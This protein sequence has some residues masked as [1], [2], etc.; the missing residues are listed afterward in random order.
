M[1]HV[2]E[3]KTA[4]GRAYSTLH[5][6]L[7]AG[8]LP[9]GSKVTASIIQVELGCSATPIR[10]ALSRLAGQNML[11]DRPSI[12]YFV[13][14]IDPVELKDLYAFAAILAQAALDT[15]DPAAVHFVQEDKT[16]GFVQRTAGQMVRAAAWLSLNSQ[17]RDIA[18]NI[19]DRLARL[20]A[21]DLR[22]FGKSDATEG[23]L[24][25]WIATGTRRSRRASLGRYFTRR[26]R[27]VLQIASIGLRGLE[28]PNNIESI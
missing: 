9:P 25:Q 8:S 6:K 4:F 10:E 12:G 16:D 27:A 21:I 5:G 20:D 3:C 24:E 1:H 19:D 7:R 23:D 17:M 28:G 18:I 15:V 13:P 22:L 14:T 26:E 2:A 11:V